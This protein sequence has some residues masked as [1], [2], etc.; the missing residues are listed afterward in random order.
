MSICFTDIAG[1][2]LAVT[3]D[4]AFQVYLRI[5]RHRLSSYRDRIFPRDMIFLR[6]LHGVG[7]GSDAG[8]SVAGGI[9]IC[10]VYAAAEEP[11]LNSCT[12][13]GSVA[14]L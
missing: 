6:H 13:T 2:D 3:V 1:I 8:N 10:G 4:V 14:E 7:A 11:L 12:V 9:S 5:L